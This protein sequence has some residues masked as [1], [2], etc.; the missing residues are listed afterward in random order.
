MFFGKYWRF[1]PFHGACGDCAPDDAA[2]A[3][4]KASTS[5]IATS[6]LLENRRL[7]LQPYPRLPLW[8]ESVLEWGDPVIAV[9]PTKSDTLVDLD[10]QGTLAK[11]GSK[12]SF[13]L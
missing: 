7:A 6:A 1:S 13:R 10:E 8:D 2:A 9:V 3:I 11:G 4:V 12:G 5:Q